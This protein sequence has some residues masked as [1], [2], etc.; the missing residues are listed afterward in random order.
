MDKS[1]YLHGLETFRQYCFKYNG[2]AEAA[3][4]LTRYCDM[5]ANGPDPTEQE[6][7]RGIRDAIA[8]ATR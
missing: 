2:P 7:C 6:Y 5:Q 8:T 3:E 4:I 1:W